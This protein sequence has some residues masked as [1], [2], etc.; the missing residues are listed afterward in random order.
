METIDVAGC[1]VA[2]ARTFRERARG[3]VGR[4]GGLLLPG[5]SVHGIGMRRP[6]WAVGLDGAGMV[7]A[8]ALLRPGRVVTFPRPVVAVLE[9]PASAVPP[10]PGDTVGGAARRRP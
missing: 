4:G 6:V 5:R 1:R 8:V 3:L 9:L 7:V 10:R 2:V